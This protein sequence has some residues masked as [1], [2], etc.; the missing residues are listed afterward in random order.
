MSQK[1]PDGVISMSLS[2][3]RQTVT[4]S[5]FALNVESCGLDQWPFGATKS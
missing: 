5:G 4:S 2:S 1:L 3:L